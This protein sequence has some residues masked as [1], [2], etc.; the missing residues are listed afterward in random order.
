VAVNFLHVNDKNYSI[1]V[2]FFK[3]VTTIIVLK[4]LMR[5]DRKF[6]LFVYYVKLI[7]TELW[8]VEEATTLNG[9]LESRMVEGK[10]RR[11]IQKQCTQVFLLS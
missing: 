8:M 7:G 3:I 6:C 10:I 1:I 9:G 5:M 2:R 4:K 11:K